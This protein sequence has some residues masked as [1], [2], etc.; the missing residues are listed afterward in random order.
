[1]LDVAMQALC[2]VLAVLFAG[3]A[4]H[5]LWLV[6]TRQAGDHPLLRSSLWGRRSPSLAASASAGLDIA[7]ALLLVNVPG[8]GLIAASLALAAYA[9]LLRRLPDGSTCQCFGRFFDQQRSSAIARNLILGALAALFGS[10]TVLGL[11]ERPES[12][13]IAATIAGGTC[14]VVLAREALF[15][16]M[17]S[18]VPGRG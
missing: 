18:A 3:A 12:L 6:A 5:K 9:A 15:V 1:M 17:A 10:A 7:I 11:L 2:F 4:C 13:G 8:P 16:V 14:L